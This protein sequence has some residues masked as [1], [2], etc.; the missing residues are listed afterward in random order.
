MDD[1]SAFSERANAPALE[2]TE[3]AA[4]I[5]RVARYVSEGRCVLFVGPDSGESDSRFQGLPTS[6]QLADE[7][8]TAV[9][10]R[11]RYVSF[12]QMAQVFEE[13]RGRQA[14]IQFL[15]ARIHAPALRPLPLH[16]DIARLPFRVIISGGWDSLL[17]EALR[18][19]RVPFDL[20]RPAMQAAVD[21]SRVLL[22]QPYGNLTTF[23]D[24]GDLVIT[25][26]DQAEVLSRPKFQGLLDR[27][28]VALRERPLLLIGY[29]PAP[30]DL[31]VRLYEA[32]RLSQR[33]FT[34]PAFA[35]QSLGR[36]D[37]IA[38]FETNGIAVITQEPGAFLRELA[39]AVAALRGQPFDLV[40]P[41]Q[42]SDAPRLT[43]DE[44]TRQGAALD[45]IMN[46]I[47]IATLVDQTDVPLLSEEQLRDIQAMRAAYERL[48]RAFDPTQSSAATWL[49]SGNLEYARQNYKRAAA[50]Y[51]QALA[52]APDLAEAHHNLHYVY[53]ALGDLPA[54]LEAYQRAVTLQ[55]NLAILPPRYRIEAIQGI[56]GVG[57]VY[58]AW[59][60]EQQQP[61]AVK[62]LQRSQAQTERLLAGFR[63]EANTLRTL[64][65]PGIVKLLDFG[66]YRGNYYIVMPFLAGETLKEALRNA[67]SDNQPVSLDRAYRLIG[68]V[69]AALT[70]THARGIVHRDLKPSNIFL[71]DDQVK[72]IDFGLARSLA[73]GQQSTTN[74]VSGTV[75]YMAPEQVEGRLPDVRSD[76][77]AAATVLYEMLTLRNPS[78]GAF[79]PAS[80]LHPGLDDAFDL[81]I[82]KAR[83]PQPEAR[84]PTMADFHSELAQVMLTQAA[85]S[86]APLALRAVSRI[87]RGARL[88][89]ERGWWAILLAAA[90]LGFG[91]PLLNVAPSISSQTRYVAV[92]LIIG[93]AGATLTDWFATAVARRQRSA[94]IVAYGRAIGAAFGLLNAI[95][96]LKSFRPE[97]I[98][99]LGVVEAVDFALILIFCFASSMVTLLLLHLLMFTG[100]LLAQRLGRRFSDGFFVTALLLFLGFIALTAVVEP[101]WLG[102]QLGAQ[103]P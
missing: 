21:E 5:E 29:A 79:V 16:R 42:M 100:G 48:A 61:V 4:F 46:Q 87:A 91:L 20:L 83:Q 67:K 7:M 74:L 39:E 103:A 97:D 9:A 23:D 77:Y 41:A 93:L 56:G 54:S 94:L 43:V 44:L 69:C 63:R 101:G 53:L 18:E 76:V 2:T 62:V 68:Q 73:P 49:R 14:L 65:H 90:V 64:D 28:K 26:T 22:Y 84:Y 17:A 3:H 95:F 80:E 82:E 52:A 55:P 38:A 8:A 99:N 11:G 60:T 86:N 27:L 58:K 96:W 36:E 19:Q 81:V 98:P 59:D 75:D 10:Y 85:S 50:Y 25:Q 70:Y 15:R 12:P 32:I 66:E 13:R 24:P 40:E 37:D 1:K 30:G 102:G 31:F 51:Q 89:T 57:V 47:G 45:N 34:P 88:A 6:G 92:M 35:V 78:Q 71:A 33:E 72:L